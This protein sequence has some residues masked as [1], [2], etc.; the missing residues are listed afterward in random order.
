VP[1]RAVAAKRAAL[2]GFRAKHETGP[3]RSGATPAAERDDLAVAGANGRRRLVE[4]APD[5][6]RGAVVERV[7]EGG[8][9]LDPVHA[10]IERAEERRRSGRR[11]N[12][13]ADVMAEARKRQ[14]RRARSAADG[15][16]RLEDE[17]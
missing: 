12:R 6:Q 11:M 13:R 14:F 9:R 2:R 17:H 10:Q 5:Q 15:L 16:G 8:G 4:R 7:R 3:K 1:R